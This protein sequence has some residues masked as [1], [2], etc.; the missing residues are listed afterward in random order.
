MSRVG[1]AVMEGGN[2]NNPSYLEQRELL[3]STKLFVPS[4]RH[5]RVNRPRLF[6]WMNRG[7]DKALVLVSAPA[8]YGKT[9]LV[10]SW[11][12]DI[13]VP[14][15]W[16]SLDE[17][18]NDPI[19]FLQYFI[20][21]L[22][23]ILP[24]LQ[25]D[26]LSVLQGML[27]AKFEPLLNIIINEIAGRAA[28]F[29]LVLDD[30]HTIHAQPV[31]E[32][33]T[34][35]LEH[36]PPQ[37]HVALLSR[38][39]P[40][41]PLSRLR[42]RN[43]LVDIRADHLR[44][45]RNEIADFLNGVVGL[46]LSVEE[47]AAMEARTEG[48]IVGLQLS[49]ISMQGLDD[50]HSF[51]T[52]FTGSHYY[53]MDYLTEEVLKRQSERVRL[54]LLQSSVLGHMCGP[55]CEKVVDPG[56]IEQTNAQ[57]MLEDLER[58]NLFLIPLDDE[59]RWYRYHH[60]FAEV[61]NRRLE[62]LYP[63]SPAE[64][65]QRASHWY[66]QNGFIPEAIQHSIAAG[67]QGHATQLIEQNGVLLLIR[68]EV[69]TLLKWIEA[70]EPHAWTHPWLY[71]Y[72]A[73]AFALTGYLDRVNGMLRTAEELISALEETT[74]VRIMKGAIAAA[75]AHQANVQGEANL[76]VDFARQ[77][78]GCL[79][80]ID[81]VSRSLRTVATSLLGDASSISGNLEEARR[82]Y[83]EAAAIGQAAGDINL[84]IVLNSN[85]ANIL[86]EQ[87]SLRQAARIYSETIQM[88]TR[89][90]GQ[91]SVIAGR[92]YAELSQVY[93]EWNHLKEAAQYVD[94]SLSLCKRWGNM[95]LQAV[96]YVMLARLEHVQRHPE[97]V[98]DVMRVAEQLAKNYD[99]APKYAVWVKSNLAR[100]WITLRNL[101]RAFDFVQECGIST[102]GIFNHD[103]TQDAE[104]NYLSEPGYLV[105]LRLL[106]AQGEYDD[107][108]MLGRRL[109]RMAEG[110]KR[111]GRMVEV[112][113]L[114]ALAF[115]GK[116]DAVRATEVLER[117]L[118]LAQPEGYVRV[119]LDEGEAMAKLLFLVKSQ[120]LGQGYASE[121]LSA[122]GG[123][124]GIE[125]APAQLLIEPL[126]SR[127][128]E[129]LKLIEAGCTNQDIADR[130][131][132]S[133]PTVKRH[134]S[135]IYAKLGAKSRTQAV[136]LGREL[137]LFE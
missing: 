95:D 129:V 25:L 96:G 84:T 60:L 59:R 22:Q 45:T 136:S 77:A 58:M 114:Q 32:I 115:H 123:V 1:P 36:V 43:Q 42:A 35:F 12:H 33:I 137:R 44:F 72:K 37:T 4:L 28:P 132:I 92:V 102:T 117:A 99:L 104:I 49:A 38:T 56:V 14:S 100:L 91:K 108:L 10:S 88:A 6:E 65:H 107:A 27:P 8:G 127:E 47:I 80:D 40:P 118:S 17:A 19:R 106:L 5:N 30:F 46:N 54:F 50:I 125:P 48:W 97:R 66:E 26:L 69:T 9:T 70:V 71:I 11:L 103:N 53:I 31:L 111:V 90:D 86:V 116:K 101:E 64:L 119:F 105:F 78:L 87:G 57:A 18:D 110:T 109:L 2:Q 122:L 52:A 15:A 39:D 133:I 34:Y 67:N 112:L 29:V 113:A 16:I 126:T 135:N 81:L 24:T 41:L 131:V 94:Q 120:R 61:L 23:K 13:G 62:H 7:L 85:L 82:A 130:L 76:A 98:Q 68:G 75:R 63:Q 83:L 93:Y 3:L 89:P 20:L 74:E 134:I 51:V 73:W 79:P 124:T 55:L 121:L 21:A 128:L